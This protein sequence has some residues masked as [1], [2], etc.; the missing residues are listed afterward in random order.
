MH[1]G[2][3]GQV[4]YCGFGRN[5]VQARGIIR[6]DQRICATCRPHRAG[7]LLLVECDLAGVATIVRRSLRLICGEQ[8][9]YM[10]STWQADADSF[11]AKRREACHN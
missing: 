8:G 7:R 10:E 5:I 2:R 1:F 4:E 11:D 3:K 6:G 9:F